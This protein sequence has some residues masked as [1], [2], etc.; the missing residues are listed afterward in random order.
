MDKQRMNQ[1]IDE[2]L[3]KQETQLDL[4]L[5]ASQSGG[6]VGR[7]SAVKELQKITLDFYNHPMF[8]EIPDYFR[9]KLKRQFK[10]IVSEKI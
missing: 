1:F 10:K 2:Y 3:Q 8:Q 5:L 6:Y 9:Y 7:E 4:I